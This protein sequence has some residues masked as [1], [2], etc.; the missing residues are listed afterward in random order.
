MLSPEQEQEIKKQL[1]EQIENNFPE[2]KKAEAKTQIESM[3]GEPFENFLKQ[4]NLIKSGDISQ[5]CVFCSIIY[6]DIPSTKIGEN[7]KA[8]AVLELNPISKAHAIIIPKEHISKEEDLPN[9]TRMLA[10]EIREK[11]NQAFNPKDITYFNT[12]LFGHEIINVLPIYNDE[13]PNSPKSQSTP[14]ELK[15]IADEL[16]QTKEETIKEKQEEKPQEEINEKNTWLP[17]RTP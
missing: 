6:G 10:K 5:Q 16:S 8:I 15:Q 2:D 9:E 3:T 14:E 12:N 7:E 4:N 11:I 1:L 17:E 13:T